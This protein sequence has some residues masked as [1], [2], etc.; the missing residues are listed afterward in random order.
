MKQMRKL[1]SGLIAIAISVVYFSCDKNDNPGGYYAFSYGD[2]IVFLKNQSSDYI[3]YP[4]EHRGGTYSAFPEG[5]EIDENTGSINV[6]K[7]ET[8]LRYRVTH[9]SPGGVQTTIK[10]VL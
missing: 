4:T 9:T 6:S 1:M 7:S 2:S 8:G 10:I 5:I 3:I